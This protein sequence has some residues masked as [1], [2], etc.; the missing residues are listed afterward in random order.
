V[1]K[2]RVLRFSSETFRR[3]VA[4]C[5]PVARV[6]L[7]AMAARSSD[8]DA[9]MRQQEKMAALGKLSAGLAHELNNPVAAAQRSAGQLR[10]AVNDLQTLVLA[11]ER[12]FSAAERR[13]LA[14]VQRKALDCAARSEQTGLDPMAQSDLEDA[15]CTWLEERGVA[16]SWRLAPTLAAAELGPDRL[17]ALAAELG[18]EGLVAILPWIDG[19]L[20]LADL[21]DQVETSAGRVSEL[22][23]AIKEYSYMDRAGQQ[24]IDVHEGL[25]STL[26]ILAH[27]LKL[28]ITVVREYD[29]TL[30]RFCAYASELNQVWTNLI[31]NAADA[32]KEKGRLTLRT[33]RDHD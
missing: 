21:L 5:A 3:L 7:S 30:P 26:K 6:V 19:V 28:G 24:E 32:M 11:R 12:P 9:Q 10:E 2:S 25:E 27:K 17:D 18:D 33:S 14:E 8:V 15:L 1:G 13:V 16:D 4:E 23:G 20:N 31:D 22:V 29:R